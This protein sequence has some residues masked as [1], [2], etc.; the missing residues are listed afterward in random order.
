MGAQGSN[1]HTTQAK[2]GDQLELGEGTQVERPEG[3][4][5]TLGPGGLY[6]VDVKGLHVVNPGTEGVHL[7]RVT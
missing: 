2:L 3:D 1:Q 4:R 6:V 5:I 7:V